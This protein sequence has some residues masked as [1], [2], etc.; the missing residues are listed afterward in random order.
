MY[1]Q[2]NDI[3][4]PQADNHKR[5]VQQGYVSS[6]QSALPMSTEWQK[7]DKILHPLRKLQLDTACMR[8]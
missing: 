2:T 5:K 8:V 1:N 6:S 3:L 4:S 7:T